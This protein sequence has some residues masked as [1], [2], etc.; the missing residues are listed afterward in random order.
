MAQQ[1]SA[2][3]ALLPAYLVVGGD[4]LKRETATKRLKARLDQAMAVFNLDERTASA[5]I[6]PTDI[7]ISLNTLAVGDGFRLVLLHDANL[8]PKAVQET[9]ISYLDN[10][11]PQCVLCLD[12]EKLA[13]NTRLYKAVAKV[14]KRSV[15][16]CTP[17]RARELPSYL[18]KHARAKGLV[19]DDAAAREL[20]SRVGESTTQLDQ[21]LETLGELCAQTRHITKDD[22]VR[23]VARTAEVKPWEFLDAV[24]AGNEAKA[25][26]LYRHMQNPSHIALLTL[27]TRRFRE[28]VCAREL[29]SRGQNTRTIASELGKQEWQ[30]RSV[31]QA[32]RRFS[33]SQLVGCLKACARCEA[34]LKSGEDPESSFLRLVTELCQPSAILMG[35]PDL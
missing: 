15:I 11:N 25:L 31:V 29:G 20:V 9:I 30:V 27:L 33:T 5:N 18:V 2:A 23:Y 24:A 28:L 17:L 35:C 1:R 8:L 22:V 32:A 21:Q 14:G 12:A 4:Q 34:E 3:P 13:K 10:P 26:E 19:I 6:D 7:A 16:D